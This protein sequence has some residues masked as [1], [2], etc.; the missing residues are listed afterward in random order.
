MCGPWTLG[1]IDS[2]SPAERQLAFAQS[3]IKAGIFVRPPRLVFH[4]ERG[5]SLRTGEPAVG[6]MDE[7][8][9]ACLVQEIEEMLSAE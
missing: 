3:R 7:E 6:P 5:H 4:K 1:G 2:Q 9:K 8:A